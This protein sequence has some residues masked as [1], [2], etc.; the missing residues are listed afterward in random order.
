MM[1]GTID[2]RF[3]AILVFL[4]VLIVSPVLAQESIPQLT[5]I[6]ESGL[7]I[8]LDGFL[9]ES[10]WNDIPV[11][12]GMRVIDPDTLADAPYATHSKIFYTERGI[13]V[14]VMNFQ[15]GD[16]LL[17]R[18]TSRDTQLDRDG[19]VVGIDASGDG[20]YGFFLRINLGDSM[21][22]ATILPER[23]MNMQWDG[24][25]NGAT[26][27]LA[28]GW[29]V[30]YFI[31]WSM[32]P[33]PRVTDAR[34]IGIY[35]ERQV[36][37]LGG[38]VWSNP[39]LPR[40]VNE[41]L[42]AYQKYELRDIEARTQLTYYPFVSS[43]TDTIKDETDYKIGTDIYWRPT[44]NTLLSA[45]LNP[46]FGNV[47]SDDVVV[48]LTAFE[49]FYP[50]K[51]TFFLEGQDIFNT[52]PRTSG[53]GGPGGPITLL[54]TRRIGGAA[55]YTVPAD[56]D[57][58]A[59]D[60]SQPSDLLGAVKVVGQAG[61]WRYGTL[62]AVEDDSRIRGIQDDG[63]PVRLEAK[64]KDFTIGRL[65]YEDTSAGGRRAIGW[66][67]TNAS[68]ADIDAA[69][70]G[71]DA[72]YFSA[73][74]RWVVDSQIMYSDVEGTTGL[75]GFTDIGFRPRR[76]VQHSLAAT[77][78]DDKLDINDLGFLSR[79]DQ[80]NLDYNYFLNE[81]D[82]EGL[83]SRS[84]AFFVTNQWNT[85]GQPVRL[86]LAANR[87]Y[88]TLS[89][90]SFNFSLQ[91]FPSRIDD[92]LGR[93]SG[94][95]RTV[96]RWGG[97]IGFDTDRSK[98][99]SF[100]L[101]FNPGTEEIGG[102]DLSTSAIIAWRPTDRFSVDLDVGYTDREAL[103]VYRGGGNY[104]SFEA[105]QWSP[106]LETSYFITAKQQLRL[107]LQWTA[108]KAFEDKFYQVNSEERERLIE[109]A[110]PDNDPDDFVISRMT[111]QVRYR[112]EIAPLSDLFIVYTRG[113][114]LPRDEFGTYPELFERTWNDKI[115]DTL[116]FK[117]RYRLGS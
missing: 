65:L 44:T 19:F 14:G 4:S 82:V 77:Y 49:T 96:S 32:M 100:G 40:T 29:S 84:T 6:D 89:N 117:L 38:E 76:G 57:V 92:R 13:Y 5:R 80:M 11:I 56:V 47:E 106:R 10:V 8:S 64:G 111:F 34:R 21:T 41:F 66:M 110:N 87:S 85:D 75:G 42:S 83:R 35:L 59:T 62:L 97:Q 105:T 24:S 18:M 74:N 99:V 9:D 58:V 113:S 45:T 46:D 55:D 104:T 50:E 63:T 102:R 33:L 48:N 101:R 88:T 73:D 71:I 114:N 112:W 26:Q 22:D 70:H 103:L 7:E 36:G 95:F 67:G 61:N 2:A 69:T 81:S 90:N 78:I 94:D 51:R 20:L 30:E 23:Q 28:D 79:N 43:V 116:A 53:R 52:S 68:H 25:W 31:P 37:H 1:P 12:D 3:A 72:H 39:P 54:N 109:V 91:Y 108:L 93:G 107:S 60:L 86:R 17:A 16:T 115:V 98:P 27:A 15:P